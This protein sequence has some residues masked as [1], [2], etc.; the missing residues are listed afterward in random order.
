MISVMIVDD[1][2]IFRE[3]LK[4]AID[5]SHYGFE[6]CC[7]AKN[8][9]EALELMEV[10]EPDIVLSD[11]TMPF[12]DGLELSEAIKMKFCSTEI[13]LITGNSEFEYAKRAVKLG[14][15]DYIVKP[16]E[17]EELIV[18]LLNL[19]DNITKA[20]EMEI[21]KKDEQLRIREQFLRRL[22]YSEDIY[23]LQWQ[24]LTRLG[25]EI[26][27]NQTF[28]IAIIE[29]ES[30][31]KNHENSEYAMNWKSV[32]GNLYCDYA[33]IDGAQYIF[34]DYE[35][36]IVALNVPNSNQY[37]VDKH[38]LDL[39]IEMLKEKLAL[40]V[41]VGIGCLSTSLSGF[42]DSYLTSL[43]ALNNRFAKGSNRVIYYKDISD[44]L[45]GY[46]FYSAEQNEI[47][48]NHL[49]QMNKEKTVSVLNNIFLEADELNY[50]PEYRRMVCM[51]LVSLLMS[52]IVKVGKN[53][54]DI[55][56]SKFKP[57]TI[58]EESSGI[59]Q[60]EAILALYI[61]VIDYLIEN[62][63]TQTSLIADRIKN[64]IDEHY[65]DESFS[66]SSLT[67]ELLMNQ[68][69]LRK[70]FKAEYNMTISE[71]LVK[72]RMKK[73]RSLIIDGK[74]KLS[75]IAEMVG[76]KDPAY[77]SR[78]FKKYYGVSPSDCQKSL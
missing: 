72:V 2:P 30:S 33:H 49:N 21:E 40:D 51:G 29:T 10:H 31:L 1:M 22:I 42:R 53:I 70:M 7:E 76:Y 65:H 34:R 67:H 48:I 64:C 14:V 11:I 74:Y 45:I 62:K 27:E 39:F 15:A 54:K 23:D 32:I 37:E 38:E 60:K 12:V 56:G 17:K 18:T 47:I 71:Y 73:S 59:R 36:R 58:I 13:V 24:E 20:I 44:E 9:Q 63:V 5:W 46:G 19:K 26:D 43:N 35:G 41:T 55:F 61:T 25:L 68:T 6:I 66:M 57:H 52:Y 75:A 78:S 69:Y 3:Y 4:E 77:F 50:S 28:Y 8:G 16:F